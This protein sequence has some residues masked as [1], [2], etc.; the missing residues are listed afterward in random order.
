MAGIKIIAVNKKASFE[1]FIIEKYEAGIVLEG[2][3]VKSV[4]AGNV[5]LNDSFCHIEDGGIALKNCYIAPY[6][7]VGAFAPE[8]RRSRK[9]L[10]HKLEIARLIGKM[11]EKGLTLVPLKIYF[12]SRFVKIELGLCKGKK[13]YDKKQTLKERDITRLAERELKNMR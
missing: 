8:P 10:L 2:S 5:S 12:K 3:E 9:L 7:N 11:R 1:Y 13:S 6:Q 4:K